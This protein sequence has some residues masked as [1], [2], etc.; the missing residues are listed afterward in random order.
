M[1]RQDEHQLQPIWKVHVHSVLAPLQVILRYCPPRQLAADLLCMLVQTCWCR[2]ADAGIRC[3]LA[4]AA[5]AAS[6]SHAAL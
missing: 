4:A 3:T 2:N 5:A 6:A 1:G